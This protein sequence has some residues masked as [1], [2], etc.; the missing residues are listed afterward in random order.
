M[1]LSIEPGDYVVLIEINKEVLKCASLEEAD[2]ADRL[3]YELVGRMS[4]RLPA[5]VIV[6]SIID[7]IRFGSGYIGDRIVWNAETESFFCQQFETIDGSPLGEDLEGFR[8]DPSRVELARYYTY[9]TIGRIVEF[10][11]L[12]PD[13]TS[14]W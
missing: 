1:K 2:Q 14:Y 7:Y 8:P 6:P 10:D 11:M 9:L 5:E 3:R 12:H 4:E 13:E